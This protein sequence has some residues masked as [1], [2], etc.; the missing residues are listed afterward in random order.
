[1]PMHTS[2]G[3]GRLNY[4]PWRDALVSF[5]ALAL[6]W[7][8]A[9][10]VLPKFQ[11]PGLQHVAQSLFGLRYD[12]VLISLARVVFALAL[13]FVI[14]LAGALAMYLYPRVERF[15]MPLVRLI[16]AVPATCWIVFSIL[17]FKGV[18][19][20]ISFVLIVCCAPIFLVDI[21]D[22]MRG[23]PRDLREMALSFRPRLNHFFRMLVLPAILPVILTSLK[24][25][26]SQAIRL[27]TF[28]ELV[29]AVSGIGYG[30]TVAQE[31]FSVSD[32]FAWTLVLIVILTV[33]MEGLALVEARLLRWRA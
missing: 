23:I 24:I 2:A 9:S 5:V 31:L 7:Q 21:L 32:V 10:L 20:R 29:G 25:N 28:A 30:L 8:G 27:V 6:V 18:E 12:F 16:M 1:M 33:A 19:L 3:R 13:S 11:V 14:G 22:G 26:L 15:A 4:E 17:W